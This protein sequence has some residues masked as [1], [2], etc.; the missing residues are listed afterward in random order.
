MRL[1][2]T[3]SGFY[4][5]DDYCADARSA[6]RLLREKAYSILA[7]DYD[8]VGRDTGC[9]VIKWAD[10]HSVLPS[11]VVLIERQRHLRSQLAQCLRLAGFRSADDTTFIKQL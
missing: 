9:D 8:L 5:A 6:K 11:Y 7:I 1:A 3:K 10:L 2:I 4:N